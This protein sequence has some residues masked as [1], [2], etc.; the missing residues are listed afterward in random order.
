MKSLCPTAVFPIEFRRGAVRR[1]QDRRRDDRS[2][3]MEITM[4][5]VS[6]LDDRSA[7]EST[8]TLAA[9]SARPMAAVMPFLRDA[10]RV[11]GTVAIFTVVAGGAVV[12]RSLLLLH[13]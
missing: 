3:R 11:A 8:D 13:L 5:L 7:L 4:T 2:R 12:L 10:A 9:H 6:A 1:S